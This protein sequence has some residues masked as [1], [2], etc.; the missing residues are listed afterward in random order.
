[1][2]LG[3]PLPDVL[4]PEECAEAEKECFNGLIEKSNAFES[5]SSLVSRKH[6]VGLDRVAASTMD[7][8]GFFTILTRIATRALDFP[9]QIKT[10]DGFVQPIEASL[11]NREALLNYVTLD[12][13]SRLDLIVAWL[14]EEWYN[15][16]VLA[17]TEEGRTREP[18]YPV[19]MRK[20][21]NA[22]FPY[23]EVKDRTFMRILSEIPELDEGV[24]RS[25]KGLCV[26]PDRAALG[27]SILQ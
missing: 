3:L 19:W 2:Q 24:F 9:G 4:N 11:A 25:V 5:K 21:L 20:V 10:E 8:E 12:W 14:N 27:V 1:M 13:R 26:D 18:Q 16:R 15:D 22:I 6:K 7:R 17:E 23:L